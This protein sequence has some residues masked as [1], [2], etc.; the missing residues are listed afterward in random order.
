V[1]LYGLD[2]W[3]AAV[4]V[5]DPPWR[6]FAS[7]YL[8]KCEQHV[9]FS[10][11]EIRGRLWAAFAWFVILDLE[12]RDTFTAYDE[13]FQNR[14]ASIVVVFILLVVCAVALYVKVQRM[15]HLV[16]SCKVRWRCHAANAMRNRCNL[17]L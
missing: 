15:L 14:S 6:G 3:R 7:R 1:L 16:L 17:A 2:A 9:F 5:R 4:P 10:L 13:R 11:S 8:K 12:F